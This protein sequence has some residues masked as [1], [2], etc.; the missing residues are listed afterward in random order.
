[1][2]EE[3]HDAENDDDRKEGHEKYAMKICGINYDD[4]M[5]ETDVGLNV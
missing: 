4:D 5:E 3:C 1:M 2:L